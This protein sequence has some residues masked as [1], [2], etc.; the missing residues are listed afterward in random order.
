VASLLSVIDD[1]LHSA[2][3]KIRLLFGGEVLWKLRSK[4]VSY[5]SVEN[6]IEQ[7]QAELETMKV[8]IRSMF[9]AGV[10]AMPES[11]R[12][13]KYEDYRRMELE[14]LSDEQKQVNFTFHWS[15]GFLSSLQMVLVC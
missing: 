1:T 6:R 15:Q 3:A 14:E 5:I 7:R 2:S 9:R 10:L 8:N 11:I 4:K 12:T 13:M